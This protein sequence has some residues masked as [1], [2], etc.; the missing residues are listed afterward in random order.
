MQYQPGGSATVGN[1]TDFDPLGDVDACARDVYLFQLLGI[2]TYNNRMRL[3]NYSVR[4]YSVDPTVNHDT[5]MSYL[6]AAGIYLILDV[7][8]PLD[9]QHLNRYEPWTTYTEAYLYVPMD[10]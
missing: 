8:S 7:N 9:G 1:N 10:I 3:V 6:A 4:V 2:N 5:C